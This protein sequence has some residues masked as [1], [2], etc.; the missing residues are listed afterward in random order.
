[1]NYPADLPPEPADRYTQPAFGLPPPPPRRPD[2]IRISVKRDHLI[3]AVIVLVI[4]A[5]AIGAA[6]N[7]G[8]NNG[9][10]QGKN[11]A[12]NSQCPS[13]NYP[14]NSSTCPNVCND[15]ARPTIVEEPVIY[16]YPKQTEPVNVQV[17]YPAGFSSTTPAYN[18]VTGWQVLATPGGTLTNLADN[19]QYPYLIWEGNPPPIKFDMSSGFVVPGSQ[20][21]A[22]LQKELPAIGLSPVE[23]AAFIAYWQPRMIS[24]QYNL[25][26]FAGTEYTD[27]AKLN[28]SPKPDATLRVLMVFT[29]L[30]RP[31]T[32][33][34]QTFPGFDRQGFTVIEWGGTELN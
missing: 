22:F 11:P 21:N 31:V 20:T 32:V 13:F 12:G 34:T 30:D 10:K 26:H 6:Y 18:P 5:I 25:I 2:R 29:P 7:I 1:M 27:Y 16:L 33:K 23:A 15:C 3:K 4:L 9:Y 14:S 24:N 8:W 28:I 19:K 17:S